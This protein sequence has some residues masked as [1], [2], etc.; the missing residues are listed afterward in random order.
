MA[1]RELRTMMR[2]VW[3]RNEMI[4]AGWKRRL[5]LWRRGDIDGARGGRTLV[6]L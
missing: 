6:V 1:V 5:V 2:R 3:V 4:W